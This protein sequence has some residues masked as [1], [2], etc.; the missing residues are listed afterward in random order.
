MFG[1]NPSVD[2]GDEPIMLFNTESPELFKRDNALSSVLSAAP[3][4]A[5]AGTSPALCRPS[6]IRYISLLREI[7][8]DCINPDTCHIAMNN[9]INEI[10]I[11]SI[12]MDFIN[13]IDK[14]DICISL[15]CI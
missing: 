4:A 12:E 13:D 1:V 14:R 6:R 9:I 7:L 15:F 2:I 3:V 11:T 8:R 5:V 10:K